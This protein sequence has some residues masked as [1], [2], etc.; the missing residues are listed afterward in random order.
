MRAHGAVTELPEAGS[1]DHLCWVHDDDEA[2]DD[3]VRAF[4]SD[5]L[6]R[7]DRLLCI[8]DRVI[9]ALQHAAGPLGD[10]DALLAGGGLVMMTFPEACTATG[11]LAV[12]RQRSFYDAVTRTAIGD[13]YRGLRIIADMTG[14]A[15]D[16]GLRDELL[17]WE[18]AGD[19]VLAGGSGVSAMCAYR[20]DLPSDVI[21]DVLAVHPLGH[22]PDRLSSFRLFFDGDRLHLTGSVDTFSAGR[23]AMLLAGTPTARLAVLDLNGLEFVDVAGCRALA[24]WV[25]HLRARGVR[26]EIRG[27]SP[28]LQRAWLILGLHEVAPVAFTEPRG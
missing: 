23:L 16:P 2:F 25:G 19:E 27:A 8:G 15:A 11:S 6:A 28:L 12:D 9:A 22:G 10:V 17:R 18:H 13:G 14:L 5:G 26:L 3:A 21:G 20:S 4:L 24:G 1:A 7:G